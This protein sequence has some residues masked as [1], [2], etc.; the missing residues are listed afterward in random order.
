MAKSSIQGFVELASGL[1]EM[2][3]ARAAEAVGEILELTA[4]A[5]SSSKKVAKQANKLAEEFVSAAET[6]R[7][8]ITRL[9]RREL[10]NAMSGLDLGTVS[11]EVES[12]RRRV[13]DLA[14]QV[15]ALATIALKQGEDAVAAGLAALPGAVSPGASAPEPAPAASKPASTATE[16][17]AK[18]ASAKKAP[19][20]TTAAKKTSAKKAPVKT[21]AA[22]KATPRPVTAATTAA[23]KAPAKATAARKAPAKKAPAKKAPATKA[24][25]TKATT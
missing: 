8:Q 3:R 25:A 16:R 6:N 10:E 14:G 19:A 15:E 21:T 12:L 13:Q 1:G 11:A 17:L 20:R 23:K 5:P 2:T 7:Q 18:K 9:I 22:K 4:N 24:P